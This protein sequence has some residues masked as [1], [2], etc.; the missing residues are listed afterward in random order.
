MWSYH[1]PISTTEVFGS[2]TN[3]T[4]APARRLRL[5][6]L[7]VDEGWSDARA[8]ERFSGGVTTARRRAKRYRELGKA[9]MVGRSSP[10]RTA[11][12]T[13]CRSGS[14]GGS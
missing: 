6:K 14:S 4:L 3:A 10:V 5:A 9:G 2:Q 8:A 12:R 1:A 7:V 11:A 13:G